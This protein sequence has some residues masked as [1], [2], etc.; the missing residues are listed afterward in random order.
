MRTDES[1]V[2]A[3]QGGVCRDD[4]TRSWLFAVTRNP[5]ID[6]WRTAC[7][8]RETTPAGRDSA[9]VGEDFRGSQL[10]PVGRE[11]T[12]AELVHPPQRRVRRGEHPGVP[13]PR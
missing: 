5:V 8:S 11:K 3:A 9:L 13:A 1:G 7:S 10:L 12:I 4:T 2:S 6:D